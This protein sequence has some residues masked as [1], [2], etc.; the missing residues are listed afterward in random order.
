[1][2]VEPEDTFFA[3]YLGD[4]RFPSDGRI[5]DDLDNFQPRVGLAWNVAGD[6]RTVVRANGGSYVARIP[7]LVFAQHRSTNGAFQQILFRSSAAAAALG[8][9][10]AIDELIDASSAPPFLPDIQ[11]ADRQSGA[12]AH[13][14]VQHRSR[15]GP[16]G[17]RRSERHL[18]SRADRSP[19]S[20]R[21]SQRSGVR[22]AVRDRHAPVRG[23]HQQPDRRRE[24]RALAL[25]RA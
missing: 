4:P 23:R 10:P 3:P 11:V 15:P 12:A 6:G 5:P 17:R 14:V 21:Q 20:L 2:F 13:L 25:P 22:L 9:V 7:M 8:P 1:M 19:F 16:G 18:R 24:Q